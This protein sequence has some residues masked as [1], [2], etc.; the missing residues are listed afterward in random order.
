MSIDEILAKAKENSQDLT[1][2]KWPSGR[3]RRSD[4]CCPIEAAGCDRRLGFALVAL[5]KAGATSDDLSN[6]I[7]AADGTGFS[8]YAELR[9]KLLLEFGL[10][11]EV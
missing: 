8:G 6:I 1:W 9:S 11:E 3:I 7:A 2:E 4:G 5:I 10:G